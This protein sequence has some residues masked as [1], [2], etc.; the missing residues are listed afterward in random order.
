[1]LCDGLHSDPGTHH[2]NVASRKREPEVS[3]QK[4]ERAKVGA[5]DTTL[6][7]SSDGAPVVVTAVWLSAHVS[8]GVLDSFVEVVESW[9]LLTWP[10]LT[11][12]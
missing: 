1:M 9:T 5:C 6:F 7:T 4:V 3:F 12:F 10:F 2:A 8:A 11:D